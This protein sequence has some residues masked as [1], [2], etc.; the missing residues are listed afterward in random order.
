MASGVELSFLILFQEADAAIISRGE[1]VLI[2]FPLEVGKLLNNSMEEHIIH[3]S[4]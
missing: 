2:K 3:L 1:Q 4:N